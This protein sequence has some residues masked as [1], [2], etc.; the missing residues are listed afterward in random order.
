MLQ[1]KHKK[2]FD[3]LCSGLKILVNGHL[4]ILKSL[5]F[6]SSRKF[7]SIDQLHNQFDDVGF[8]QKNIVKNNPLESA[9]KA[10]T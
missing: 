3:R 9:S 5:S 7:G 10:L 8:S 2:K 4:N 6:P 1:N